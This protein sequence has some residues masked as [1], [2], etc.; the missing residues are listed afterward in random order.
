MPHRDSFLKCQLRLNK[1]QFILAESPANMAPNVTTW[2]WVKMIDYVTESYQEKCIKS[3]YCEVF[4][5]AVSS[6]LVFRGIL[7][8]LWFDNK[9]LMRMKWRL[10]KLWTKMGSDLKNNKSVDQELHN[11][12]ISHKK[13]KFRECSFVL[14]LKICRL[15]WVGLVCGTQQQTNKKV[16]NQF[17]FDQDESQGD[18]NHEFWLVAVAGND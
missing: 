10:S 18:D 8:L 1:V 2:N 3:R 6:F 7:F 13:L 4:T 5:V 12:S 14:I 16:V 15:V 11:F 17:C 9:F